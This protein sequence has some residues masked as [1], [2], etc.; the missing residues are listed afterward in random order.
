MLPLTPETRW[1]GFY[2]GGYVS[3]GR[4][5]GDTRIRGQGPDNSVQTSIDAGNVASSLNPSGERVLGGG[6]VGFNF[7][8]GAF[9][10]GAET[11]FSAAHLGGSSSSTVNPFGVTVSTAAKN[12]LFTLGTVRG[13]VGLAFG[14]LL[15][16]GSGGYAYGRVGQSGSIVP[17]PAQ[18]P[19]YV[20]SNAEMAGGWAAGG[21]IEYAIGPRIS[22]KLDYLHYNL[23]TQTYTLGETTGLVRGE[24]AVMRA[25]T[26]GDVARAGVNVRF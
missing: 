11:D 14:D 26:K 21:G 15:I 23:G 12:E 2:V 3:G 13:R 10:F 17:N 5:D 20:G 6:L 16:F 1:T 9:V 22:L 25:S 19:T 4:Q 7:Q 8:T 18:N 24:T